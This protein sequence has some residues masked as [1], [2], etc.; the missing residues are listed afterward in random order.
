MVKRNIQHEVGLPS[1]SPEQG[2]KLLSQ[3]ITKGKDLLEK[4]PLHKDDYSSWEL[5]ARNYLE[6]SF[7]KNSPNV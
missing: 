7:G 5:L 3:L 4:R 6:K 2:I 1:V